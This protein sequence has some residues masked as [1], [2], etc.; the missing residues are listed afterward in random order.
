[1]I[2]DIIIP[3]HQNA[4]VL[5]ETIT[6]LGQQT[7]PIAWQ[8]RVLISDDGSID[9]T[10]TVARET[11]LPSAWEK[12]II[13]APHTGPGG[14]RNRALERTAGEIIFFLGADILLRPGTLQEHLIFHEQ[15]SAPA[16]AA[17][18]LV[19]WDPRLLP[20]PLMEWMTHGGPQNDFDSL[21]GVAAAD[22]VRFFYGSH[23]SVKSQ[24]LRRTRFPENFGHYGWEDLSLGRELKKQGLVLHVL[25][26]AVSLH[27]HAYSPADIARRQFAVG[28]N[29]PRFQAEHPSALIAP[30][31][32]LANHL[33]RWLFI[34]SGG[35]IILYW[36]IV[37]LG[38][39]L[40]LPRA[41]LVFTANE[42]WKGVWRS[43]GGF[44]AYLSKE[45]TLS[46]DIS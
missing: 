14:A 1:M 9:H 2:C 39:S 31:R 18:G 24:F 38:R 7:I 36:C 42:F 27:R 29:I 40:S 32:S 33:R 28:L 34:A 5:S 8:I 6:A 41:F 21:L 44:L 20:T 37:F 45:A 30:R 22:P 23:L 16:A 11:P 43:Q 17:L 19:R 35:Q 25:H 13:Q 26:Q 15:H 3:T 12:I 46:Q 10:V 4:H